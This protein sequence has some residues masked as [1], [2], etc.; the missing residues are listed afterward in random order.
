[1]GNDFIMWKEREAKA[2]KQKAAATD[3]YEV[4]ETKS[5]GKARHL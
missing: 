2:R 3:D 4:K 5:K 1:M